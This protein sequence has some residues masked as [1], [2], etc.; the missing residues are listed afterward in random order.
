M[1]KCVVAYDLGTGVTSSQRSKFDDIV[2]NNL[3]SGTK[4]L[5][6]TWIGDP[7]GDAD[8]MLES[9]L[10]DV[11]SNRSL[12]KKF[13][14]DNLHIVILVVDDNGL[15]PECSY[16]EYKAKTLKECPDFDQ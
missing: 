1:S 9:I 10:S 4:K 7:I 16:D 13:K 12:G 3:V 11:K 14:K 2:C 5:E 8:S 15:F 6:T